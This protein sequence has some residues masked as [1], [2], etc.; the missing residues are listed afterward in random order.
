MAFRDQFWILDGHALIYRALFRPGAP[1]SAPGTGEPTRGTYTFLS[2]LFAMVERYEPAYLAIALDA[3]RTSTF[4]RKL[5]PAYKA[6]RDSDPLDD[7]SIIQLKRIREI[8]PLLGVATLEVDG[9]EADDVIGSLVEVC[10]SDAVECVVASSDKDLHQLVGPNVRQFDPMKEEWIDEER[11][12]ERWGVPPAQV[13]DVQALMGDTTD[14]LPGVPGIGAK[15]ATKAIQD[16]GS[17][18]GLLANLDQLTKA[19]R[20]SIAAAD[21]DLCRQLVAVRRDVPLALRVDDLA[22]DGF[23]MAAVRPLFRRLGFRTFL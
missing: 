8:I 4:R 11:V 16:Y 14:N 17:L 12:L 15:Y 9:F 10:A 22:F 5:F 21:L 3:P 2:M 13:I 23:D 6:N 18:E 1:L 20:D 7:A 19:K